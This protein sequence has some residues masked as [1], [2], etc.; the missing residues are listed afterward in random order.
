MELSLKPK[1]VFVIFNVLK[2]E[3]NFWTDL[4]DVEIVQDL[5]SFR[6]TVLYWDVIECQP[7]EAFAYD[8]KPALN[9]QNRTHTQTF[10]ALSM[11]HQRKPKR[12]F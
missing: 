10:S 11:E 6:K 3:I 5:Y 7:L 9:R 12:E 2:K 1:H 8:S 4:G